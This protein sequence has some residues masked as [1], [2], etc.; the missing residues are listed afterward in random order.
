M[1]IG[2]TGGIG[3]GKTAVSDSF[4]ALGIDIVDADLASRV[5]VQKGK[6]CLAQI[7]EHFGDDILNEDEELDRAKLREIIFQSDQEK[8]WLESLLHPAIA[9]Q[10]KD[11]LEASNSPYTILVSPL[12]F[13]TNQ[14]EFCSKVL[15]VDV[16]VETQVIRTLE[17]DGVSEEQ[18][19]SIINSQI[20]REKRLEL[21]DEVILNN[22]SLADLQ[23][24]VR[25]LHHKFLSEI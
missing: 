23:E 10:I 15:V 4:E 19:N 3:S 24:A 16:P 12:L 22:G 5:V 17:R 6:P 18:V 25:E 20:D 21:A 8:E 1:I 11:E 14:K 7:Q 2:L 13:E 9:S